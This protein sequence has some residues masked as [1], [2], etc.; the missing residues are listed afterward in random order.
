MARLVWRQEAAADPVA[1]PARDNEGWQGGGITSC[2][3][4][5]EVGSG[6]RF[7]CWSR[8]HHFALVIGGEEAGDGISLRGAG[9]CGAIKDSI[10]D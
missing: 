7:G 3:V 10:L 8:N 9:L 5:V 1:R 6:G 2:W 4:C